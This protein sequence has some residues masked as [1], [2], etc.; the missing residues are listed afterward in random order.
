MA[1][2]GIP[3]FGDQ[4]IVRA[5]LKCHL[6]AGNALSYD[7][8]VDAQAWLDLTGD[9][10]DFWRGATNS[11][12][13]F[14]P[15]FTGIVGDKSTS[16]YWLSVGPDYFTSQAEYTGTILRLAGSE[17]SQQFTI[18]IWGYPVGHF[19]EKLFGNDGASLQDGMAFGFKSTGHMEVYD[20]ATV[21]TPSDSIKSL[22][23]WHQFA[24][25]GDF[26]GNTIT[27]YLD[28]VADGTFT[29]T[30]ISSGDSKNKA[31]ILTRGN[32]NETVGNGFRLAIFRMYDRALAPSEIDRNWEFDRPRFSI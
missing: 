7:D 26:N 27:Y 12:E 16:T 2:F 15:V 21:L 11:V 25:T 17:P 19:N 10:L 6:D 28:G 9:S 5:G 20:R 4:G 30:T 3:L 32:V 24:L 29:R 14:D 31:H 13:T 23:A 22:N 18:E 1:M 8:G